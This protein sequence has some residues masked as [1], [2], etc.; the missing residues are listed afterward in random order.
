MTSERCKPPVGLA[1]ALAEHGVAASDVL[2]LTGLPARLLDIPGARLSVP[3]Y[4]ALW[5]AIGDVSGD[6]AIGIRLARSLRADHT[7][8]LF[9]AVFGA[10]TVGAALAT[11][12]AYKRILTP[13]SLELSTSDGQVTLAWRW[14][15]ER[16]PRVLV[17]A[18]L[19]FLVEVSR[20]A[21]RVPD[22]APRRIALTAASVSPEHH[23]YFRCPIRLDQPVTTIAF[24]ATDAARPFVSHNPD[25]LRALLP[26]LEKRT[27]SPAGDDLAHV[28]RAIADRLRGQRPSLAAV[29][30]DLAMS[31]RALQ[32]LLHEN[33]TSYRR[34]LDEVR[35][36]H[37][38]GYLVD[39]TFTD[40]EVAFL[41]GFAD[42]T[43]FYRAFRGWNGVSPSEYRRRA[44]VET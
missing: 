27:P 40:G 11:V 26:Y 14:P 4:F 8:P 36:Q 7:E 6:P 42:A 31:G 12:A 22:L 25:L 13:E 44:V 39:T 16:P 19:T 2:A 30:R 17:D 35:N 41:L 32:R 21:T 24:G 5:Q 9:L 15:D 43:S 38:R 20:R 29:G 3:D 28:R 10:A 34:L 23:D 33:G 37:A 18:E 1:A